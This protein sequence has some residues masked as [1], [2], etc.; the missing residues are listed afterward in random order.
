MSRIRQ[1]LAQHPQLASWVALAV[2]MVIILFLLMPA[3]L[4]LTTGQTAT[5]VAS[6]IVL[7]GLCLWIIGWE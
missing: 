6:T 2:G 7:A 1:L 3:G 4:G 5:L